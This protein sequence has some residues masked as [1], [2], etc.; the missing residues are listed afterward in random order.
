MQQ[1]TV[2]SFSIILQIIIALGLI[3]VWLVRFSKSTQY[4][5]G[6]AQNMTE[7]FKAYGLPVWFMYII[8]SLK[9]VIAVAMIV[10]IF[11]PMVVLPTAVLLVILMLGAIGAHMRV[12]DLMIKWLPA[13]CMLCFAVGLCWVAL[14]L[15]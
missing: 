6:K 13:L 2:S 10:G 5:G 7:E 3:N 15:V 9:L 14:P 12:H 1:F 11:V 4:R 8:G